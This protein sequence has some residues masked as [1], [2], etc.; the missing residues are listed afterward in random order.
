MENT[1]YDSF[2]TDV[3]IAGGGIAGIKAA[4]EC[5]NA[6]LRVALVIKT[7]VCSGS[8]FYPLTEALGCLAP[9]DENDKALFLEE[10][11][12][13]GA[14]MCDRRMN[15]I[16]IDEI[17]DRVHELPAM[18][19]PYRP[20]TGRIACFAKRERDIIGWYDWG[21]LRGSVGA[22]LQS[23]P[24]IKILEFCDLIH[25]VKK[26]GRIAGA[27]AADFRSR[28]YHI[29]T[30]RVILATGGYCGLY[31]HSLNTDDVIGLG[32]SMALD[33]GASLVNLEFIQFIPGLIKPVYKTLFSEQTLRFAKAILDD[34]GNDLLSRYLPPH[35]TSR[36]C[37][38]LRS[39]HGPFTCAENSR[40]FDISMMKEALATGSQ[41]GYRLVYSPE[42]YETDNEFIRMYLDFMDHLKIHLVKE[43]ITIG[44]F[45]QAANGGI[46]IDENAETGVEG[47]YA[48][49][50]ATGG[51][52]GADRIGG[53]A[54]GSCLV[55]GKRA[56]DSVV[57]SFRA[58]ASGDYT[59]D[60]EA[61]RQ[62]ERMLDNGI[63][64]ILLPDEVMVEIK[65]I[66]WTYGNVI[67]SEKTLR[68]AL[69]LLS[70]VEKS[71]NAAYALRGG[72]GSR[73]AAKARHCLR[74]ARI[75][76]ETMEQR[77]ESR[78]AHYR[79]DYPETDNIHFN[80]RIYVNAD[81]EH[82]VYTLR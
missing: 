47:L 12:E 79:D 77:K 17:Y 30:N 40:Y 81:G 76:L 15:Q 3:L 57:R 18:G 14:G 39:R 54:S 37:L 71:Y 49:G 82:A 75:I 23:L 16:Y 51:M 20:I 25:L 62:Y 28:L 78:G 8:S 53:L 65:K 69:G 64:G 67:R 55:F 9:K 21:K 52:H 56:A 24:A 5:A 61:M 7:R 38:D 66:L 59:D 33:A 22:V 46:L 11:E 48:I 1:F 68:E 44:S 60:A 29:K 19:I 31:K 50:E 6:G 80:K 2:E 13:A 58:D 45:G 32:Q 70:S 35:V 4:I 27:V 73:D 43:N 26:D 63:S 36:E 41:S 74:L 42:I 34:D 10:I 72:A